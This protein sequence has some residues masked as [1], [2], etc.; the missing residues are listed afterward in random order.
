MG[1]RKGIF[2]VCTIFSLILFIEGTVFLFN[3]ND[4]KKYDSQLD[5]NYNQ[6]QIIHGN[7][8]KD[9]LGYINLLV[10]G[11]DDSELRSDV[12]TVFNFHPQEE[13]VNILSIARDTLI[14]LN[15]NKVV[16][17]N[18]LIGIGGEELVIEKIEQIT[19]MTIHFYL[20]MNFNGL[21]QIVDTLGGVEIEVPFDMKYDDPY[22]N[23]HI[24]LKKGKQVLNGEKA[25]QFIRYRKGNKAGE[26]Y[27]DGDVGRI[28]AQQQFIREFIA[29]KLKIKYILKINEIFSVL[30]NNVTTNIEIGDVNRYLNDI[31]NI[32]EDKVEVFVLPGDS[33]YLDNQYYYIYDKSQTKELI[34]NNFIN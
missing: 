11:L 10:I 18:S 24:N 6:I 7:N 23:L 25:E 30:K 12:I 9:Y 28:N 21:R 29:Q 31:S 13:R 22:Q 2:Y 32:K 14:K 4:D 26:G 17:I 16:K 8:E 15:D 33:S 3:S 27:I 19:D 34:K 20:T 5:N 1:L